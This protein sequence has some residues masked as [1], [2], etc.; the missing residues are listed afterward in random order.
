[1]NLKKVEMKHHTL[2]ELQ[3][4]LQLLEVHKLELELDQE[5]L[6]ELIEKFLVIEL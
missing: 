5:L 3:E 1:M 4:L 6:Q 2:E